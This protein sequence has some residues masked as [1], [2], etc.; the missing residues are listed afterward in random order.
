MIDESSETAAS[1]AKEMLVALCDPTAPS[2]LGKIGLA[3][4]VFALH[5]AVQLAEIDPSDLHQEGRNICATFPHI[6]RRFDARF[7]NAVGRAEVLT[8]IPGGPKF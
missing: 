6:A 4:A 1:V 5:S 2:V 3:Q 8:R 7:E